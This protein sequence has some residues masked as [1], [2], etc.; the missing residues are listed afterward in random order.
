MQATPEIQSPP[1]CDPGTDKP[2][3]AP[4][5]KCAGL[6][7]R[8]RGLVFGRRLEIGLLAVIPAAFL[9]RQ[10]TMFG[11][12]W[13]LGVT[14]SLLFVLAGMGLRVW[15]GGSAGNHTGESTIRAPRLATGGPYAHVRNP[16][17]L[18]TIFIGLGMVGLIGDARLLPVCLLTFVALYAVI[19]PAEEKFLR[20]SFGAE[21]ESYFREVPRFVPRLVRWN[22]SAE[23]PFN[24]GILAGETR[25]AAV[26]IAVYCVLKILPHLK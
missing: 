3:D 17:Y 5:E 14:V 26:L 16:I 18:G 23:M 11:S 2:A 7:A 24:W 22:P 12:H 4:A 20:T 10:G 19:I 25:I 6:A 1:P 8:L 21:Y 15:A 13:K 9:V